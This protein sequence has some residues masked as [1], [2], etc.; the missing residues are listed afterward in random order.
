ME[1]FSLANENIQCLFH[2][3]IVSHP[4]RLISTLATL[5]FDLFL[6]LLK[7]E[8]FQNHKSVCLQKLVFSRKL[9]KCVIFNYFIWRLQPLK[10][11]PPPPLDPRSSAPAKGRVI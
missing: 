2:N 10:A 4:L 8:Y 3:K 9:S 7:T 5:P 1:Y 11:P 6:H